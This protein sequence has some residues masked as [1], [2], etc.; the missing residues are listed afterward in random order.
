MNGKSGK[1]K[2][3]ISQLLLIATAFFLPPAI[4]STS[5]VTPYSTEE[6]EELE[7]QFVQQINQSE[8]IERNPLASQYINHIG[9]QL[10]KFARIP[11]P[12]SS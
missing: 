7:K 8:S 5:G 9:K 3:L 6:L 4:H 12:T 1:C 10:A 2:R 11:T